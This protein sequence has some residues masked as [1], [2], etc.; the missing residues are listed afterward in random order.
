MGA[1]AFTECFPASTAHPSLSLGIHLGAAVYL[2]SYLNRDTMSGQVL[3]RYFLHQYCP[4]PTA[5]EDSFL[6]DPA[7]EILRDSQQT[8]DSFVIETEPG[9]ALTLGD[10]MDIFP[11]EGSFHFR[12]K[13]GSQDG[14]CW[15]DVNDPD[16]T[17]PR[18]CENVYMK[19][20]HNEVLGQPT[21]PKYYH[22]DSEL[23]EATLGW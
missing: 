19:V 6:P 5:K 22:A 23:W 8:W 17:V 16:A 14:H 20:R 2:A 12:F 1:D 9:D 7:K 21:E 3:V 11:L 18:F 4:Q 10:I 15:I 13:F